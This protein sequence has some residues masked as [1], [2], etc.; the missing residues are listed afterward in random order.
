[1]SHGLLLTR[2]GVELR[3]QNASRPCVVASVCE[4]LCGW[5]GVL[6]SPEY[7]LAAVLSV[8]PGQLWLLPAQLGI[9][10]VDVVCIRIR[11][12]ACIKVLCLSGQSARVCCRSKGTRSATLSC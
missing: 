10:Y 5:V 1:M 8:S 7:E 12:A 4:G 3:R 6:W 11:S 9:A 2:L